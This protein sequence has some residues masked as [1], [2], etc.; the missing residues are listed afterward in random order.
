MILFLS[1]LGIARGALMHCLMRGQAQRG[2]K[3]QGRARQSRHLQAGR[4]QQDRGGVCGLRCF[5]RTHVE[6]FFFSLFGVV[7]VCAFGL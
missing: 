4:P 3:V 7:F 6:L 5:L 2:C 1:P